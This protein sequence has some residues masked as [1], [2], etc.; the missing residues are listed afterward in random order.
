MATV[1]FF[2]TRLHV[3]FP[4][5]RDRSKKFG[6]RIECDKLIFQ[7]SVDR[8]RLYFQFITAIFQLEICSTSS[9]PSIRL[10]YA[11][12]QRLN[13]TLSFVLNLATVKLPRNRGNRSV[14]S[15]K[16]LEQTA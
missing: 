14:R 4:L 11:Y 16:R 13:G 15:L 6:R 5:G 3:D 9:F 7:K 8:R 12:F 2:L 1:F 10:I